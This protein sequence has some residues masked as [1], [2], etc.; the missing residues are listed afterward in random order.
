ME[1][2]PR[3]QHSWAPQ[4][5]SFPGWPLRPGHFC[6]QID[7]SGYISNTGSACG[8]GGGGASGTINS[9]SSGP[10]RLLHDERY[11]GRGVS[12]VPVGAGGTGAATAGAAL[13][14]LGAVPLAGGTMTGALTTTQTIPESSPYVDIR[15]FGAVID[16]ATDIGPAVCSA[17]Q[18]YS[19]SRQGQSG[20]IFL[21]CG[22]TST[23]CWWKNPLAACTGVTGPGFKYV[24]QGTLNVGTT[25]M[26]PG[27]TEFDGDAGEY[28]TQ[29]QGTQATGIVRDPDATAHWEL[30]SLRRT[31]RPRSPQH[32]QE[33]QGGQ[34]APLPMFRQTP[35]SRFA[36]WRAR[37]HRHPE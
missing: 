25:L 15:S 12:A 2:E 21:P 31:R 32:S 3:E 8:S 13:A 11:D 27:A 5:S 35:P 6:L 30:R 29:F 34:P 33:R 24:L 4:V 37:L 26:L 7:N 19:A 10:D 36:G 20:T 9:G 14:N 22:G 28:G 16:N 18:S 17:E 23:A 1:L